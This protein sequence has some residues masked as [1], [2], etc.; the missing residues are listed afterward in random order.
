MDMDKDREPKGTQ[1]AGMKRHGKD[2]KEKTWTPNKCLSRIGAY[3]G[4]LLFSKPGGGK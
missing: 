4:E 2:M 1:C 3:Q